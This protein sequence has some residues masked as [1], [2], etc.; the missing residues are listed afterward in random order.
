VTTIAGLKT[1]IFLCMRKHEL[2]AAYVRELRL[3]PEQDDY[4]CKE[5]SSNYSKYR[6]EANDF[7][8]IPEGK[9]FWGI[10]V[11]IDRKMRNEIVIIIDTRGEEYEIEIPINET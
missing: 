3:T 2:D 7:L 4:L 1:E 10:P 6:I 11:T 8:Q 9:K 5:F